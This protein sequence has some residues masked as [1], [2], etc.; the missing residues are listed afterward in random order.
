MKINIQ[1]P[2]Q[3]VRIHFSLLDVQY[4]AGDCGYDNIKFFDGDSS[5]ANLL[6]T[7]CG[8]SLPG[9]PININ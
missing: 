5:N 2:F 8:S 6:A 4:K 3:K 9:F 7:V 1:M